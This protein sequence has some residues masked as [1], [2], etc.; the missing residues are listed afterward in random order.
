M[1]RWDPALATGHAEI[2][3]QHEEVFERLES[4]VHA[5][6][7]GSSRDEVAATLGFLRAHVAAHFQAEEA[8]MREVAF[9]GADAHADE[10]HRFERDLA[11]LDA[12]HRRDGPSP[13]LVLRV[14][15]GL[16]RWVREHVAR[17][18]RELVEHLRAAGQRRA[19][20]AG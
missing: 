5:I 14:S 12:E 16:T 17:S 10:H 1:L 3:R 13:S 20:C 4:L 15:G 18:D 6:R 19:G 9:P 11:T 7:A 8:L 2:D